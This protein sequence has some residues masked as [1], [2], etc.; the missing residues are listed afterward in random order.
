MSKIDLAKLLCHKCQQYNSE[1]SSFVENKNLP[2]TVNE[3]IFKKRQKLADILN[4]L[5]DEKKIE[6]HRLIESVR[7]A[8]EKKANELCNSDEVLRLEKDHLIEAIEIA[9]WNAALK[10][11]E[12]IVNDK[13]ERV[14]VSFYTWCLRPWRGITGEFKSI[15]YRTKLDVQS[16]HA[17]VNNTQEAS[18]LFD[19]QEDIKAIM[20]NAGESNH[21]ILKSTVGKM[22]SIGYSLLAS[23]WQGKD[24]LCPYCRK[25]LLKNII[26]IN[27]LEE[28]TKLNKVTS[29]NPYTNRRTWQH[30][31]KY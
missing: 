8:I 28:N 22:S 10:Y 14:K 12:E 20:P 4:S 3:W 23:I 11:Q 21:Q 5:N 9:S 24:S 25:N 16:G 13:G 7:K 17:P 15:C 18:E 29:I 2:Q 31:I 6:Y 1:E 30:L 19:L 26:T 27:T